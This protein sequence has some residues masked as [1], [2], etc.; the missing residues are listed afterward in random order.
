MLLLDVIA[1]PAASRTTMISNVEFFPDR[2]LIHY[3]CKQPWNSQD[4]RGVVDV[5]YAGLDHLPTA[6]LLAVFQ[7]ECRDVSEEAV[8]IARES[9]FICLHFAEWQETDDCTMQALIG[10]PY[11]AFLENPS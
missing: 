3:W 1:H 7:Q 4:A 8:W 6:P 5:T 11:H 9:A 10:G 2:V